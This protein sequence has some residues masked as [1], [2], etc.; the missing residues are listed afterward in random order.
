MLNISKLNWPGG[1]VIDFSLIDG[2]SR[3]VPSTK[4]RLSQMANMY[5][6]MEAARKM[7]AEGDPLVYEFYELGVPEEPGEIAFGT[8]ITY[9]GKVG[10]EYFMTKGHFHT[11]LDTA[12]VYYTLSG[13]GFMLTENLEGDVV[14][15]ALEPGK[16]VYVPKGY[17]HRSVNAGTTPL[18]SFFAF[19][20][21]AGHNYGTIETK[22]YR[23]LVVEGGDGMPC[24]ID[25][26]KWGK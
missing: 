5:A 26:P 20:G 9:P 7:I 17:A 13:T 25:N 10:N 14:L 18:V 15:H 8:S 22:G 3:S 1:F 12:E 23:K 19:R 11:V 24:M 6:D 2:I 16:A 4:R 21:D